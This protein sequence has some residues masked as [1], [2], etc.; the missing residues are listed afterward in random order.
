MEREGERFFFCAWKQTSI[1]CLGKPTQT[2]NNTNNLNCIH[3]N[4]HPLTLD[5]QTMLIQ[6]HSGVS[7][8]DLAAWLL[9]Q[10]PTDRMCLLAQWGTVIR[11]H[12]GVNKQT[13]F[14]GF[15][16]STGWWFH[17]MFQSPPASPDCWFMLV[18]SVITSYNSYIYIY[19]YMYRHEYNWL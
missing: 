2:R 1:K 14:L 8:A 9:F 7:P 12:R 15:L 6:R 19:I 17:P 5:M 10:V 4:V 18:V 11:I 3:W 16:S 13:S